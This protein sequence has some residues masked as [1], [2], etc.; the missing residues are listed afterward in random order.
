MNI[1]IADLNISNDERLYGTLI[2]D[3]EKM[4]YLLIEDD[5]LKCKFVIAREEDKE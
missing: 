1:K 5:L 3:L 4:G 2:K